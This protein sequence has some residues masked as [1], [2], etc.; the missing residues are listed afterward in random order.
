MGSATLS[1]KSKKQVQ[2]LFNVFQCLFNVFQC[3]V[4]FFPK[5]N[6]VLFTMFFNHFEKTLKKHCSMFFQCVFNVC[7][8]RRKFLNSDGNLWLGLNSDVN[9]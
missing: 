8:S 9:S 2:C 1:P 3:F 4:V 7:F 5:K 6:I